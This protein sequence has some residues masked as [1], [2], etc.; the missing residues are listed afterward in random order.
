M[1]DIL[2][3]VVNALKS[4]ICFEM[5][6]CKIERRIQ[7]DTFGKQDRVHIDQT[8][9]LAI[10]QKQFY[11]S[12]HFCYFPHIFFKRLKYCYIQSSS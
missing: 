10:L 5:N 2:L 4:I 11:K 7:L 3:D 1:C 8:L 6:D 9:R 12:C